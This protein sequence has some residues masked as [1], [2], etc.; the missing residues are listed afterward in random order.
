[1]SDENQNY[2]NL[3]N[4]LD[5]E[6]HVRVWTSSHPTLIIGAKNPQ[7]RTISWL[8]FVVPMY[9]ECPGAWQGA[10]FYVAPT[11]ELL[12]YWERIWDKGID[13][14]KFARYKLFKAQIKGTEA[15]VSIIAIDARLMDEKDAIH[16]NL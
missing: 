16:L 4:A 15:Y 2:F 10:S 3:T 9:V 12:S 13:K 5:R 11:D 14:E 7:D 8:R 1:M 6:C